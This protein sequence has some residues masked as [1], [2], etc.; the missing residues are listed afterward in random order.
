MTD[1]APPCRSSTQV[2]LAA[3]ATILLPY[4][5]RYR[6]QC[7]L[8]LVLD[9]NPRHRTPNPH[10]LSLAM[11]RRLSCVNGLECMLI[12]E[13]SQG[14]ACPKK[15]AEQPSCM[16]PILSCRVLSWMRTLGTGLDIG[17]WLLP[18]PPPTPCDLPSFGC[19]YI[20][21]APWTV[22][23]HV[24]LATHTRVMFHSFS[25]SIGSPCRQDRRSTW[26]V[27]KRHRDKVQSLESL[28]LEIVRR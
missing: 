27:D 7:S 10:T 22:A 4:D 26:L 16:I 28:V 21:L 8:L 25:D 6:K 18:L 3:T 17:L 2:P 19:T 12:R 9:I 5:Q 15:P 20:I 13:L 23:V 1:I 14:P 11:V 24:L